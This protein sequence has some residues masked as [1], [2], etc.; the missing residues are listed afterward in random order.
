MNYDLD[1]KP[2]NDIPYNTIDNNTKSYDYDIITEKKC[3]SSL[4]GTV[5]SYNYKTIYKNEFPPA[6]PPYSVDKPP[7]NN[8]DLNL[9]QESHNLSCSRT[10]ILEDYYNNN[11][12][13]DLLAKL[14]NITDPMKPSNYDYVK[15]IQMLRGNKVHKKSC[16]IKPDNY[17]QG[18]WITQYD[19]DVKQAIDNKLFNINTKRKII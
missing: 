7:S 4:I 10:K 8:N 15:D 12:E 14:N 11:N 6:N 19:N 9:R 2:F 13:K 18:K 1:I 3:A 17:S 5:C 16:N